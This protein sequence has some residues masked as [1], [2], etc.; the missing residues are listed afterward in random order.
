SLLPSPITGLVIMGGGA[1]NS[2]LTELTRDITG[3]EVTTGPFEATAIG[4][5]LMQAK[6]LGTDIRHLTI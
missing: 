4:N 2:L 6:S 5:I 1:K 3:L